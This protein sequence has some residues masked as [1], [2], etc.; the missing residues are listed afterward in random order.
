M[1]AAVDAITS[2]G[3]AATAQ[4]AAVAEIMEKY[5]G[6]DTMVALALDVTVAIADAIATAQKVQS[7]IEAA[8]TA[9]NTITAS[10]VAADAAVVAQVA[11]KI[12]VTTA[13]NALAAARK[14]ADANPLDIFL[15]LAVTTAEDTL[16]AV[17]GAL[18][19]VNGEADNAIAAAIKSA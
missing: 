13:E 11:T 12:Q 8:N 19:L 6:D 5:P 3:V 4:A 9:T 18:E 17:K 1:T 16:K 15:G 10:Y 2:V 7:Q 14:V